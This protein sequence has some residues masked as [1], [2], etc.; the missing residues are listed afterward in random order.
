MRI[1][2]IGNE[3][4][5]RGGENQVRLLIEG[6]K[7]ENITC[8]VAYPVES[9]GYA[10]FKELC[11]V[12]P[13]P[14]RSAYDPRSILRLVKYCRLNKVDILDAQSSGGMS[15]AL[16]VKKRIPQIKLVV[17]RRV[18]NP[19]KKNWLTRK[20]YLNE[21][22]DRYI[23]ISNA[24]GEILRQYGVPANKI[25]IVRSAVD[26]SVYKTLDK[27]KCKHELLSA[28]SLRE[29]T[30]I[31]GNASALTSQKGYETLIESCKILKDIK[32]NFHCF[33]AGDGI[34]KS[35]LKALVKNFKLDSNITFLG[36][37]ASVHK[38]LSGLDI[39][40]VPSRNEGLGTILL[41]GAF[42]GCALVG[43]R[44]GGIPEIITHEQTG[45]SIEPGD[46]TSLASELEK[47]IQNPKRRQELAD[48]AKAHVQKE[49]SLKN[50]V[51]GNLKIYQG[52]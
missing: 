8:A 46:L 34:L 37:I 50:M 49:F 14:S 28:Y 39:L 23:C 36:H 11:E 52:L 19:I 16:A 32:L 42:A 20:K 2:H 35:E 45:L 27:L 41:E 10:R 44:V 25:S 51:L 24:I 13:L 6:L 47:I 29:D 31:L 43:A 17:H 1:L 38:F 5:W 22:V 7:Q 12:V 30:V 33:I 9:R 15:L 18:D 3:M 26:E 21:K 48:K 40:V 4:S